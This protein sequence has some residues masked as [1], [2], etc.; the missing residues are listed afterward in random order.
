MTVYNKLVRDAIPQIIGAQG[1][2]CKFKMIED[3]GEFKVYL[4]Q[5]LMEEVAEFK[6]NPSLEEAADVMEVFEKILEVHGF[7]KYDV[8]R[9]RLDKVMD[10]G[11]FQHKIVLEEV[12]D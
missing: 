3:D 6:E 1:K 11:A 7:D 12:I 9:A 10:K 4:Y 8:G 2:L 5:K